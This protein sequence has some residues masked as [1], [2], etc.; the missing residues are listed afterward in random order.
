MRFLKILF[1]LIIAMFLVIAIFLYKSDNKI[2]FWN[3]LI[4]Q[5]YS[6]TWAKSFYNWALKQIWVVKK[7]DFSNWYY[8]GWWFPPDDIWVCS[9]VIRRSFLTVGI[10]FKKLIDSDIKQNLSLYNTNFDSNVNFRR[11]KNINTFFS[12]KS[13]ILTN[14]LLSNNVSN[15]EKWQTWD[16]VIFDQIPKKGLLHIAIITDKRRKDWVPYMLDNHWYWVDI[17]ITPLDWSTKIIGHYRYF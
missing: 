14:E 17:K 12:R 8:W 9:D 2:D 16:I 13:K 4:V 10:D 15:L 7:Y 1:S 3:K 11:V 5:D 6:S